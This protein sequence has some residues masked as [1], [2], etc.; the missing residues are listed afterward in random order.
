MHSFT[1]AL[2]VVLGVCC[3]LVH[4]SRWSMDVVGV[5][6]NSEVDFAFACSCLPLALNAWQVLKD[7]F[8]ARTRLT[9][10]RHCL[11]VYCGFST[12]R[13]P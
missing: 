13:W 8:D 10:D 3:V 5:V 9:A 12:C 4:G 2:T 6:A 7:E 11:S 1:V